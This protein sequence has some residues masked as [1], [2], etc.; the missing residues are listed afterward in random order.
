MDMADGVILGATI[1]GGKG[2]DWPTDEFPL[3]RERDKKEV[4]ICR[5][6]TITVCI[7]GDRPVEGGK[8]E[9]ICLNQQEDICG[10]WDGGARKQGKRGGK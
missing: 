4:C 10:R 1:H 8:K 2:S 9:M 7:G 5:E 6:A 3:I